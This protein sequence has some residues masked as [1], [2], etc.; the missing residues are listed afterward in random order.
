MQDQ[1]RGSVSEYVKNE[2][3][4]YKRSSILNVDGHDFVNRTGAGDFR[5]K[6]T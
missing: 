1:A 3:T 2:E 5:L 4:G 6:I